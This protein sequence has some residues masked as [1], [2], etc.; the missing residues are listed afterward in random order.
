MGSYTVPL[1][2]GWNMVGSLSKPVAIADAIVV[3][4]GALVPDS[5]FR[6]NTT[7]RRYDRVDT[8]NPGDGVWLNAREDCTFSLSI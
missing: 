3:P 7:T 4:D 1:D 5:A 2:T 6:Y 8:I